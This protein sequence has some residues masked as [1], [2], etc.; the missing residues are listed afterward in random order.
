MF[1]LLLVDQTAPMCPG[2][3]TVGSNEAGFWVSACVFTCLLKAALVSECRDVYSAHPLR[4]WL[5]RCQP[6]GLLLRG[7]SVGGGAQWPGVVWLHFFME[8]LCNEHHAFTKRRRAEVRL[9]LPLTKMA[10]MSPPSRTVHMERQTIPHDRCHLVLVT[11]LGA[12]GQRLRRGT[13]PSSPAHTP[14]DPITST[15]RLRFHHQ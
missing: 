8:N 13:P 6:A 7:G 14:N 2:H 10:A 11:S 5:Q 4:S 15:A 9:S 1:G 12:K 3:V